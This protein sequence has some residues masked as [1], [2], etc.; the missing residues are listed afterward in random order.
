MAVDHQ[1]DGEIQRQSRIGGDMDGQD[2]PPLDGELV[3]ERLRQRVRLRSMVRCGDRRLPRIQ[4]S[5]R[6]VTRLGLLRLVVRLDEIAGVET[7]LAAVVEHQEGANPGLELLGN[8]RRLV[9][10][11]LD[12][13]P[14]LA[15]P[16]F[17][18]LASFLLG[19]LILDL[20]D[21]IFG[22]RLQT[23]NLRRLLLGERRCLKL[24]PLQ[25]ARDVVAGPALQRRPNKGEARGSGRFGGE[26]LHLLGCEPLQQ[27]DVQPAGA[28]L[29]REQSRSI[30]P[31]AAA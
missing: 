10:D 1:E 25:P 9:R 11:R 4:G 28:V 13:R 22:F 16:R 8:D 31:P 27:S 20:H 19:L 30:R 5:G 21:E 24:H 15:Q 26:R 23:L 14:D 18:G 17:G 7:G 12:P 2:V 3:R 6:L 29:V